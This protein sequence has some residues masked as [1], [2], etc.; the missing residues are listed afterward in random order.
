MSNASEINLQYP[1]PATQQVEAWR[2]E[3][4]GLSTEAQA[5]L[6]RTGLVHVFEDLLGLNN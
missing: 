5:Q 2:A 6:A 4:Q 1:D 3:P